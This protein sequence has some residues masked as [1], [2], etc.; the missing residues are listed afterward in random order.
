M[1]PTQ[2]RPIDLDVSLASKPRL[3]TSEAAWLLG[4]SEATL[5][6]WREGRVAAPDGMPLPVRTGGRF[7]YPT[8]NVLV[9]L[10]SRMNAQRD[11]LIRLLRMD[12]EGAFEIEHPYHDHNR[13][14]SHGAI[15]VC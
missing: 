5:R 4:M 12:I 9:F 8:V 1:Q 13:H 14:E 11:R 15:H 3:T 7:Y 10:R 2:L 6:H